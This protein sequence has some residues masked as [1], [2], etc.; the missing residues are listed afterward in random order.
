LNKHL[1]T[2]SAVNLRRA[3]EIVEKLKIFKIWESV[4][5]KANIVGSLRTGLMMTHRDI[6]FHIY[7]ENFKIE[8]SFR[9]AAELA[10]TRGVKSLQYANLLDSPDACL[11]WHAVYEDPEQKDI[12]PIDMIHILKGSR[13]DGYFENVADRI[14]A[15]LT[16]ETREAVLQIKWDTPADEKIPAILIYKAV[17]KDGVRTWSEFAAWRKLQPHDSIIE[18]MP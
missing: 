13:Y 8:D 18:W 11:E 3:S 17:I 5:A 14:L 15:V 1:H 10:K 2:I 12:W 4:G 9:A 6:D 16:A 7:S